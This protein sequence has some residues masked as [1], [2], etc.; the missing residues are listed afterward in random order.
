MLIRMF[1]EVRNSDGSTAFVSTDDV[2][3]SP[4][5]QKNCIE[6]RVL[7]GII[8]KVRKHGMSYEVPYIGPEPK[9]TR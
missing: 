6:K 8:N 7:R 5:L 2:L 3:R 9:R 1:L 4:A